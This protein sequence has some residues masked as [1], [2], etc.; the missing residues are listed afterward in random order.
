M[1]LNI[2]VV[3]AVSS[4]KMKRLETSK[5][6]T[7]AGGLMLRPLWLTE[8]H[9]QEDFLKNARGPAAGLLAS[10]RLDTFPDDDVEEPTVRQP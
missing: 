6:S 10:L 3:T 9:R 4:A 5:E 8:L 2:E 1:V 7:A